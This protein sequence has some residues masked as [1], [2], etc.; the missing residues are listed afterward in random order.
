DHG[1]V[2]P[3]V[4]AVHC[5]HSRPED[6]RDYAAAGGRVCLCPV[7]EG[8][9]GDG[10]ADLTTMRECG[11]PLSVGTDL[12]SRTDLLEELRWLEYVQRVARRKRGVI[13]DPDGDTG[14][15]LLRIGTEGGAGALGLEAGRLEVGAHAD[16]V[17]V[18]HAHPSLAG[19]ED[20]A[21]AAALVFSAAAGVVD[22]VIIGG[23]DA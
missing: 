17:L 8:N 9:L 20:E 3:N 10:I 14:P 22:R 23:E 11:I 13:V 2:A 1:V 4:V 5:T 15:E 21:L 7:T 19:V 18:D 6:L 12:N 16:L